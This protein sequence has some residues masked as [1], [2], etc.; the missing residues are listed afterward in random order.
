MAK[1]FVFLRNSLLVLLWCQRDLYVIPG[2]KKKKENDKSLHLPTIPSHLPHFPPEATTLLIRDLPLKFTSS[3]FHVF[4]GHLSSIW[5]SFRPGLLHLH[6]HFEAHLGLFQMS[7]PV[8]A[9]IRSSTGEPCSQNDT[10]QGMQLEIS[11]EVVAP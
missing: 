8:R 3:E 10:V 7:F 2:E 5:N 6:L 1:L 4:H 11:Q 9:G